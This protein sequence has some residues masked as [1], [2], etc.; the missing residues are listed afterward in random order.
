[1][2][3]ALRVVSTESDLGSSSPRLSPSMTLSAFWR[4]YVQ[5]T[6]LAGRK[7]S[8][9]TV[10]LYQDAINYWA[11]FTTDPP[12]CEIDDFVLQRFREGLE[13][14]PGRKGPSLS[15]A[16]IRKHY[17]SVQTCLCLTGPRLPSAGAA[18]SAWRK[19]Q[20]LLKEIPLLEP[21][22]ADEIDDDS[23]FTVDEIGGLLDACAKMYTP[24]RVPGVMAPE[25]WR[26]LIMVAYNTGERIGA[27]LDVTFDDLDGTTLTFP[28][29]I[30][31][32]RRKSNVVDLNVYAARA[33]ER[34]RTDREKI[35]EWPYSER[36]F[37]KS[38]ERLRARAGISAARQFGTHALRKATATELADIDER[39]AQYALG[40]SSINT[41]R[42]HY[43][44]QK[45]ELVKDSLARLPQPSP[46]GQ[47]LLFDV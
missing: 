18:G 44:K 3:S 10:S 42:G 41:T 11:R 29:S 23:N 38:W 30:R 24:H 25:W 33:I 9:K 36:H 2:S 14:L 47:G 22:P 17:R 8:W 6:W 35:F 20:R 26:S 39:A 12:L 7:A 40:H 34:I 5:P 45:R 43:I 16:S 21:P 46:T 32:G 19:A 31:K 1:M 37:F 15:A 27:L 13:A 4:L 28:R